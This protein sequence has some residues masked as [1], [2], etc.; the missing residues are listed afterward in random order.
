MSD[1]GTEAAAAS[2]GRPPRKALE[3][4]RPPAPRAAFLK[5]APRVSPS[6]AAPVSA[7]APS[8]SKRAR[9]IFALLMETVC[10]LL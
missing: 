9:S 10:S 4:A 5:N 2:D 3:P 1:L 6:S 7:R 8:A